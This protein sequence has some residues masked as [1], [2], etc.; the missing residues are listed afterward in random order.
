MLFTIYIIILTYFILGGIGFYFINKKK[1][2]SVAHNNRIKFITYFIIIH[3]LFL[4]IIFNPFYF[5]VIAIA[6]IAGGAFELIQSFRQSGFKSKSFFVFVILIFSL[7]CLGFYLFS[8]LNSELLLFTFLIVSIFDSFS[9]ISGQLWGR[10]KVAPQISPNKTFEGVAGGAAVA[11]I[12]S[13]LLRDLFNP[14]W[15]SA[16]LLSSGIL[17]F[18]FIGDL[19]ASY[20]KRVYNKKD[21]SNLIPGHGGI[22]DRFDSLILGGAWV[23]VMEII[24]V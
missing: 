17:F 23:A 6:I 15:W 22:L 9:Q 3:V 18:A 20:F 19:A 24:W 16:L 12:G 13:I 8:G 11:L 14:P 10:T 4:S 2:K 5:R 21:F 1:A 7:I